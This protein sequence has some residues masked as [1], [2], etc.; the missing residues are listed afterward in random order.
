MIKENVSSST[1]SCFSYFDEYDLT[2]DLDM[3]DLIS[4]DDVVVDGSSFVMP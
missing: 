2:P 1:V 4:D 3:M